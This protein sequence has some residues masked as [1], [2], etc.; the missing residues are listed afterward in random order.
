MLVAPLVA[1][2][3]LTPW[4]AGVKLDFRSTPRTTFP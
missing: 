2:C 3:A 1:A 4:P